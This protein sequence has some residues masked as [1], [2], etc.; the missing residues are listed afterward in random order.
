MVEEAPF[1]LPWQLKAWRKGLGY[2][3]LGEINN[4]VAEVVQEVGFQI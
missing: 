2:D 4:K 1:E 3:C